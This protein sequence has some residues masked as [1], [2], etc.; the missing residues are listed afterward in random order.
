MEEASPPDKR[1][2][3]TYSRAFLYDKTYSE[4]F[5]PLYFEIHGGEGVE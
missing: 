4:D 5:M 1:K 2:C 3:P